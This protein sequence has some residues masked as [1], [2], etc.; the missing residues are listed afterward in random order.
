MEADS[1]N[2]FPTTYIEIAEFDCLHDEGIEFAKRLS[3]ENVQVELHE[4][5]GSCHRF[6]TA[7]KSKMLEDA[8]NKRVKWIKKVL[9]DK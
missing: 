4:I 6:E 8:M 7:L 9:D 1:L 5:T 2:D 3:D